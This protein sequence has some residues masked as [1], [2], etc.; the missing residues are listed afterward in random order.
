MQVRSLDLA[1]REQQKLK[2]DIF[3]IILLPEKGV[4]RY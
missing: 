2:Q 1:V 3:Y 4:I